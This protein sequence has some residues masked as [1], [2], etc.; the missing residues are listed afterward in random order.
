MIFRSL[1]VL[2]ALALSLFGCG[3]TAADRGNLM[4]LGKTPTDEQADDGASKAPGVVLRTAMRMVEPGGEIY[5][6]QDFKNP[7]QTDVAI[8]ESTSTSPSQSF[9]CE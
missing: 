1:V 8:V 3:N 5:A 7:F 2:P 4:E 6:C 9:D